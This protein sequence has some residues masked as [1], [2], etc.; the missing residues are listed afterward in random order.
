MGRVRLRAIAWGLLCAYPALHKPGE[1]GE[2]A[3]QGARPFRTAESRST[4]SVSG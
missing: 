2:A 3:P 4:M 1:E